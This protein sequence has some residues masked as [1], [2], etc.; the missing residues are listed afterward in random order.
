LRSVLSRALIVVALGH[1][2]VDINANLLPVM[3]PFIKAEQGLTYAQVGFVMACYSTTSSLAQPLLGFLLDRHGSK[4]TMALSVLWMGLLIGVAGSARSFPLLVGL[5]ALAGLGA[6]AYHPQGASNARFVGGSRAATAISVFSLTGIAGFAIGPMAGTA[7]FS[8]LGL[9]GTAVFV[10]LGLLS[11]GGIL[12]FSRVPDRTRAVTASSTPG[13]ERQGIPVFALAALL[14]IVV[15]RAILESS[16]VA[17]TPQRFPDDLV[18]SSRVLFVILFGQAV[19]ILLGGLVSDR[20][21]RRP[22]LIATMLALVP[23][24]FLFH[25]LSGPALLVVA[26]TTGIT[27]GAAVPVSIVA[28]QELLP[29]NVGVAS[30][31]IMGFAFGLG[32][33]GIAGIGALADQIGLGPALQLIALAPLVGA[34]IAATCPIARAAT[35]REAT[36]TPR[37]AS[38]AS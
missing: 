9:P 24:V 29:R 4:V 31:L 12:A 38:S 27:M 23:Q 3:L 1:F 15:A 17:Y 33:V 30:G 21:E 37:S 34:I 13:S 11:A 26:A 18:Y 8:V 7:V 32:G 10:P 14:L 22:I 35:S 16:V 20:V 5:V 36:V 28:A 6:A 19:G 25:T 2:V